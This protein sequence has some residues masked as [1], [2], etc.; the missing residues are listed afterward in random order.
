M[1]GYERGMLSYICS[2]AAI[3]ILISLFSKFSGNQEPKKEEFDERQEI[4]RNKGCKYAFYVLIYYTVFKII[5]DIWQETEGGPDIMDLAAISLAIVV[6]AAYAILNDGYLPLNAKPISSAL[7]LFALSV[8]NL[9]IAAAG[10]S[11]PRS[12][13]AFNGLAALLAGSAGL[14]LAV[15]ILIKRIYDKKTEPKEPEE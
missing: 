11:S 2:A 3:V 4:V 7:S 8:P 14:I 13:G 10:L 9:A 6:Y 5:W 15:M 1:G 12:T